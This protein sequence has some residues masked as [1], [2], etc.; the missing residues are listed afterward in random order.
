MGV[1]GLVTTSLLGIP[2]KLTPAQILAHHQAGTSSTYGSN[3]A[4]L[5]LTAAAEG[6][7]PIT[8]E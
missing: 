2:A 1:N 5:V 3:Y 7:N 4:T 6:V 8:V